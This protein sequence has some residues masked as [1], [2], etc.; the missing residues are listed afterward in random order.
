VV[1]AVRR[2]ILKEMLDDPLW[3]KA[4][5]EAYEEYVKR[6]KG[7]RLAEVVE[8]YCRVKGFTVERVVE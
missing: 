7:K 4:L 8:D 3:S 1:F 5:E 6:G 2:E